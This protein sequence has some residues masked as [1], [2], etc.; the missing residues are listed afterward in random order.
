MVLGLKV[1][2]DGLWLLNNSDRESSLIHYELAT[3]RVHHAYKVTGTGHNFN[4]LAIARDGEIYL[5]DTA[6]GAIWHLATGSTELMRLPGQFPFAN[7]ITLSPDSKLLF[8]STF[9][10]GLSVIDLKTGFSGNLAHPADLCLAMIDGLY[11]HKGALIAIQNAYMSPRV[12]R[13]H[14]TRDL[15]AIDRFEVLERRNP[16]FEGVTTGVIAGSGFFYM[17]NIQD[18]KTDGFTPITILKLKL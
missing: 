16:L 8:V 4:D 5:T 2:G 15:R 10:D 6:A 11:F 17:A 18:D 13:L 14:L 12:V 9:P 7:G 3:A 1:H